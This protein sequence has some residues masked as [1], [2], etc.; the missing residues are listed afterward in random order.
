MRYAILPG[1]YALGNPARNSPVL[2]SS[3][4]KM[5]FD[6]LRQVLPG[7]NAWILVL[8]SHGVNVWCAAGKGLFSTTELVRRLQAEGLADLIEHRKLIVPQ[9]GASG[10]SA[11]EVTRQTGFHVT[12]GPVRARDLPEFTRQGNQAT[13]AMR[14]VTFGIGERLA[15]VPVELVGAMKWGLLWFAVLFFFIW[16]SGSPHTFW[17]NTIQTLWVF[18]PYLGAILAGTVAV[19]L[20][21]PWIPFRSFALKGWLIGLLWAVTYLLWVDPGGSWKQWLLDLLLLPPITAYLALNFTGSCNFTSL[22]GVRKE[23]RL[24]IP[25]ILASLSL[26]IAWMLVKPLIPLW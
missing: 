26:G 13:P 4:Y 23:M 17:G 25:T 1:I 15:L 20:L 21:L 9:L 6:R 10:I 11:H 19:P 3:N 7:L 12:Y 18:L 8:N 16:L 5:S 14:E 22:S 24:A 2:V